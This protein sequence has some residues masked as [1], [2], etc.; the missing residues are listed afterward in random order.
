M[1]LYIGGLEDSGASEDSFGGFHLYV[2]D[3]FLYRFAEDGWEKAGVADVW[4]FEKALA[5]AVPEEL[6]PSPVLVFKWADFYSKGFCAP[7]GR[8]GY[9]AWREVP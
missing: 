4:R 3:G 8:F 1:R 6:L 9:A 7:V 2:E 5:V